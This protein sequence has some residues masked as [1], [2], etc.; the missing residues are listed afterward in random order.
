MSDRAPYSRVYWSVVD[1]PKFAAI[2]DDDKHLSTW[3]RLLLVADQAHPA[4]ANIPL[5]TRR[6]SVIAL[7]EAGLIDMGTGSRYRVHGLDAERARRKEAATT[8][9]PERGP[10]GTPTVPGREANGLG[11]RGLSLDEPRQDETSITPRKREPKN[12][13]PSLIDAYRKQG[14][15]VDA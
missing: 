12:G 15:P 1:D 13:S 6:T 3:L 9:K 4:S 10:N 8:R 14:M 2:Y 11:V 5:G 7:A